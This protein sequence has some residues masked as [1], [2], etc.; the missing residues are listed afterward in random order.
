MD[1]GFGFWIVILILI[2]D[3]DFDFDFDNTYNADD[4]NVSEYFLDYILNILA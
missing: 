2:F 3:F 1:F 4:K